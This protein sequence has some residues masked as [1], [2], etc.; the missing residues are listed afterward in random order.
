M[1]RKY[2][3]L[4]LIFVVAFP[5]TTTLIFGSTIEDVVSGILRVVKNRIPL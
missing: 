1:E 5:I 2:I 3:I 4:I